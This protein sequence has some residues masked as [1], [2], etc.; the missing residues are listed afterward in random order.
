MTENSEVA[1]TAQIA[2]GGAQERPSV[3]WR[4]DVLVLIAAATILIVGGAIFRAASAP[5]MTAFERDGL[6]FQHPA[7][8]LPPADVALPK[9]PGLVFGSAPTPTTAAPADRGRFHQSM[10]SA[11]FPLARL[12]VMIVPQPAL[13]SVPTWLAFERRTRYGQFYW[14]AHSDKV[15]VGAREWFR[16]AFEYATSPTANDAPQVATGI[17]Y[18]TLNDGRLYVVTVHGTSQQARLLED[19]IHPTLSVGS[20]P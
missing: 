16:T 3:W 5:A 6:R 11:E 8:F 14:T 18:A 20:S 19:Q 10:Q 12:E 1:A 2:R 15:T 4:Y 17:E 13:R 7:R 9:G